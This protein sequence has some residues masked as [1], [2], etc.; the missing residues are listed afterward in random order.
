M[1]RLTAPVLIL[2]AAAMKSVEG[3]CS[4][5]TLGTSVVAESTSH[6]SRFGAVAFLSHSGT[7]SLVLRGS[8]TAIPDTERELYT[9]KT[10]PGRK[11]DSQGKKPF[12]NEKIKIANGRGEGMEYLQDDDTELRGMQD[13]HHILL[14]GY[15]TYSKER[16]TVPYVTGSLV[17]VLDMPE[18]EAVDHAEFS[19]EEGMSCLGT[20]ARE[21]CLQLGGQLQQR[22]LVCRV[23]PGTPAGAQAW[24]AKDASAASNIWDVPS[25]SAE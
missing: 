4:R 13:P 24:Q 21:Q 14:M 10:K 23:V 16:I 20:W 9:P 15:E 25:M 17:Y 3:F 8:T 2:M 1:T 7:S 22:D 11:T 19:K 18:Q 6:E 5:L 12:V